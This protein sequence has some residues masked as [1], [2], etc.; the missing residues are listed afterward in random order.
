[1]RRLEIALVEVTSSNEIM[2]SQLASRQDP[3][4]EMLRESK[5][6]KVRRC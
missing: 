2:R 3:V 6:L 5:R 1:V 4:E